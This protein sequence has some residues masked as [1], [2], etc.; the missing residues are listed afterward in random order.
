MITNIKLLLSLTLLIFI[1][2][3]EQKV[4]FFD[5]NCLSEKL[6]T[7]EGL[8]L[9]PLIDKADQLNS[10][11]V[12]SIERAVVL[13]NSYHY[14]AD[15]FLDEVDSLVDLDEDL[16]FREM[17]KYMAQCFNE[18]VLLRKLRQGEIDEGTYNEYIDFIDFLDDGM[19][20]GPGYMGH[21]FMEQILYMEKKNV[22]SSTEKKE[23]I[24]INFLL[25]II[26]KRNG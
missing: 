20:Y 25:F 12:D 24:V 14:T 26:S 23:L 4:N 11:Q 8:N 15:L 16:T 18:D 13:Y 5:S 19:N 7:S 22:I 6:M 2:C 1:G 21:V 9:S 10:V 17:S 3:V